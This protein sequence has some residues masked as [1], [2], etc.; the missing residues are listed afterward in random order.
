MPAALDACLVVLDR[1]GTLTFAEAAQGT[2]ALLLST[3]PPWHTDL[4][5]TLGRL[6]AAEKTAGGDRRAAC[7]W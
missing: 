5:R 4:E 1:Y 6:I 7:D 3:K 2:L